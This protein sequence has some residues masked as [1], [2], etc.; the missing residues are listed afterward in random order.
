MSMKWVRCLN[1][2]L[3]HATSEKPRE[4][5]TTATVNVGPRLLLGLSLYDHRLA[6]V[7]LNETYLYS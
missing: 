4:S 5:P 7:E 2:N 6:T 3:H 1:H